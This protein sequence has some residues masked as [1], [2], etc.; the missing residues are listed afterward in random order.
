[1]RGV[2]TT[3]SPAGNPE[4]SGRTTYSDRTTESG[5]GRKYVRSTDVSGRRGPEDRTMWIRLRIDSPEPPC[6]ELIREQGIPVA[7]SG[8]LELL[9]VLS[10]TIEAATWPPPGGDLLR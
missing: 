1:M 4:T 9:R 2:F 5:G 3:A 10:E 8:W 6:G 7:F